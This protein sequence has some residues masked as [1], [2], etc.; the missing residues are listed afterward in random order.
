MGSVEK[1]QI[2][3][4][5]SHYI[6][7]NFSEC[8]S[9]YHIQTSEHVCTSDRIIIKKSKKT[10]GQGILTWKNLH[11]YAKSWQFIDLVLC[12]NT[13][14]EAAVCSVSNTFNYF[15]QKRQNS[16]KQQEF[17]HNAYLNLLA[18]GSQQDLSIIPSRKLIQHNKLCKIIFPRTF[19]CIFCVEDSAVEFAG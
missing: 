15:S 17:K 8:S 11:F 14:T 10:T 1:K 2:K 3:V 7:S 19:P 12:I 6:T 5:E 4:K 13:L 9:V 18:K 16:F